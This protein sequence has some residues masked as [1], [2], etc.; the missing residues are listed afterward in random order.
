MREIL[1]S[2]STRGEDVVPPAS[3]P[4]LLYLQN[5]VVGPPPTAYAVGYSLSALRAYDG[6]ASSRFDPYGL[7]ARMSLR[8]VS[9]GFIRRLTDK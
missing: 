3:L 2:G 7:R 4:L 9:V 1:T 5:L 8:F 6:E